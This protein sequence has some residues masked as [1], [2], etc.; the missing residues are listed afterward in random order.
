MKQTL[1]KVYDP[2]YLLFDSSQRVHQLVRMDFQSYLV[3]YE[4]H[5]LSVL[6]NENLIL[7]SLLYDKCDYELN[8][9]EL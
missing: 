6:E 5:K 2:E 9:K 1:I 7:F 3:K 8:E 4:L